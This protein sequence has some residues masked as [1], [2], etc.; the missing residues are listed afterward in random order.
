MVNIKNVI[1]TYNDTILMQAGYGKNLLGDYAT[2][3]DM[4]QVSASETKRALEIR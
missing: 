2:I 1:T 4:Q 3:A